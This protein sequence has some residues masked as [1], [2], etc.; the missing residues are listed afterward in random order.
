MPRVG[1]SAW[2]SRFGAPSHGTMGAR[3]SLRLFISPF[4]ANRLALPISLAFAIAQLMWASSSRSLGLWRI[5]MSRRILIAGLVVLAIA[6]IE[7][8]I[9][10]ASASSSRLGS[11]G[12]RFPGQASF[13][14]AD[15]RASR[16]SRP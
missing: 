8:F 7:P 2:L 11:L 1:R 13:S 6:C 4:K 9:T 15:R 16:T 3:Q 10:S 5:A 14:G 12:D